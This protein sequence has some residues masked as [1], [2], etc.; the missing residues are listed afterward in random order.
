MAA[1]I[2]PPRSTPQ[3]TAIIASRS[4]NPSARAPKTPARRPSPLKNRVNFGPQTTSFPNPRDTCVQEPLYATY[5]P[6]VRP[7]FFIPDVPGHS[8]HPSRK[9]PLRTAFG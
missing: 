1:F 5:D 7:E 3:S 4:Q 8:V 2:Q 6:D 9:A